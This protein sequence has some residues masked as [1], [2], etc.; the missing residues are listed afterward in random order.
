MSTIYWGSAPDPAGGR[1]PGPPRF[2]SL[3]LRRSGPSKRFLDFR[4]ILCVDSL[5]KMRSKDCT[6]PWRGRPLCL[7]ARREWDGARGCVTLS[8]GLPALWLFTP[9]ARLA[10]RAGRLTWTRFA[11]ARLGHG[12]PYPSVGRAYLPNCERHGHHRAGGAPGHVGYP[13]GG[14]LYTAQEKRA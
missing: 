13:P 11:Q 1:P 4:E 8:G 7:R 9:S 10:G 14:T 2:C 3:P 6:H 5:G 12:P